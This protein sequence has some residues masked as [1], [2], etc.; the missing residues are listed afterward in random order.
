MVPIGAVALHIARDG[1]TAPPVDGQDFCCFPV[2]RSTCLPVHTHGLFALPQKQKAYHTTPTTDVTQQVQAEWNSANVS[3]VVESYVD[4]LEYL[5]TP[6]AQSVMEGNP[7]RLYKYWPHVDGSEATESLIV[8]PLYRR[9]AELPM[10]LNKWGKYAGVETGY[11]A[12][13]QVKPLVRKFASSSEFDI[14]DIPSQ[15]FH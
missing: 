4:V 12:T 15:G 2:G 3:N 11:I 10:F 5:T 14:F 13:V 7:S 9:L 6:E 8:K 1:H